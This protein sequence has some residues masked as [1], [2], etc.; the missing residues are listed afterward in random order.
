MRVYIVRVAPSIPHVFFTAKIVKSFYF[1]CCFPMCGWIFVIIC[2]LAF[3]IQEP[4]KVCLQQEPI[5]HDYS[6]PFSSTATVCCWILYT[7]RLALNIPQCK[8]CLLQ[9]VATGRLGK[10]KKQKVRHIGILGILLAWGPPDSA[11]DV[12][13]ACLLILYLWARICIGTNSGF[14]LPLGS[15]KVLDF[16]CCIGGFAV[17]PI[18]GATAPCLCHIHI[19]CRET[20]GQGL[21]F[22][23]MIHHGVSL[24]FFNTT[25]PCGPCHLLSPFHS[26]NAPSIVSPVYLS[27]LM[28]TLLETNMFPLPWLGW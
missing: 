23:V 9:H 26:R 11:F 1:V 17:S 22:T 2:I 21:Q 18:D 12:L 6:E 3:R 27:L 4:F 16:L 20:R 7:F 24:S 25:L 14:F 8:R 10:E 15:I 19:T 28:P 13:Y 5:A